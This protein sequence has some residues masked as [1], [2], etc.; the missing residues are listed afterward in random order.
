MADRP[1]P[2]REQPSASYSPPRDHRPGWIGDGWGTSRG[3]PRPGV[4]GGWPTAR[5]STDASPPAGAAPGAGA[6]TKRQAAART[7]ARGALGT[8]GVAIIAAALASIGTYGV[9]LATGQ[10]DPQRTA[11]PG[12]RGL[13]ASTT[14]SLPQQ[15]RIVEESA[16][17]DAASRVSPTVV[18]VFPRARDGD[19][20]LAE[21]VGSGV[22]YDPEGWVVTNR[23][24]VCLADSVSVQLSD[25]RRYPATVYGV[26]TLTDLAIVKIDGV[27]AALP[28]VKLG[29]SSALDVGQLAIAIGSPLGTFTNSVTTGVVSA[30]GRF[31]DIDDACRGGRPDTLRNLIQTDAA[32]NPGN[33]GGA[34][35]DAS[36]LLI[37]INTAIAGDAQGI[38]FAIPVNLARPIMEQATNGEELSRPWM[39]IYYTALSP[40]IQEERGLALGYGAIVEPPED[41]GMPAVLAGSPAAEADL[42][43]G[44][45]ITSVDGTEIDGDHPLDEILTGYYAGDTIS[46]GVLRDGTIMSIE[47]R[48]GTRPADQ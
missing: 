48:L 38:G 3:E 32:I 42:R 17:T 30:I 37:G 18:T 9:L 46:L 19:V 1:T 5:N 29:N 25:G 43:E 27:Q 16:I 15:V 14:G 44:D 4:T 11:L 40:V 24:V 31:I 2:D 39:G 47:L 33:S 35:V 20:I 28:A 7:P 8:L 41:S 45:V 23:H 13:Q 21:G 10:L 26:D 34:L 12:P 6:G 22:I 36:G